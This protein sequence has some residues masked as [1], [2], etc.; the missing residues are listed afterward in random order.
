MRLV[1]FALPSALLLVAT[2]CAT[3]RGPGRAAAGARATLDVAGTPRTYRL[4]VPA[5]L[6][7]ARPL[8]LVF[9]FHGAGSDADDIARGSGYDA[10][11]DAVPMIVA[12]PEAL[13]G[14]FDV[15]S[16]DS[17][18]LRFVDALLATLRARYALD[19]RRV[20]ATGFSNGAAFCYR[21]A[22]SRPGLLAAIAP[23][24]G[25]LPPVGS[26]GEPV[27]LLHVHGTADRRVA[28]P[29]LGEG[30]A[31]ATWA[32]RNGATRGPV[33]DDVVGAPGLTIRR[34]TWTGATPRSDT[35]L[36]RVE[37]K[38]HTWP[39]GPAGPVSRAILEFFRAH[40]R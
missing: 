34:A 23:V 9:V 11:A 33:V 37:G 32:R 7:P 1:R 8:P 25:Y 4:H 35:I 10:L 18:D 19:P 17:A 2:A 38:D 15:A 40:P 24:A 27:P 21:L 31:I 12:Y 14:R 6:D 36:W 5:G 3:G 16:D 20:Y 29:G 13:G 39:G 22:A 30:D 26:S 28:A